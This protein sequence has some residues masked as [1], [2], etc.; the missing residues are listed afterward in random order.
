MKRILTCIP[1]K[2]SQLKSAVFMSITQLSHTDSGITLNF[3]N[4]LKTKQ[5]AQN[6]S[7]DSNEA[8]KHSIPIKY[9]ADVGESKKNI[10]KVANKDIT[11]PINCANLLGG[12][13]TGL[14]LIH[15]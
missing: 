6:P 7:M 4:Q 11:N 15:I 12:P 10:A 8:K 13:G 2:Y 3:I 5:P 14:S 9:L 1:T